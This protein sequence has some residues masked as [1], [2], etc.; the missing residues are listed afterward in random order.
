MLTRYKDD[1]ILILEIVEKASLQI[2]RSYEIVKEYSV[3]YGISNSAKRIKNNL[4]EMLDQYLLLAQEF[5]K[6]NLKKDMELQDIAEYTLAMDGAINGWIELL[7]AF[8]RK[9]K[10]DLSEE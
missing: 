8:Y 5:Y 6:D 1:Y 3:Q 2:H 10:Y 4:I 9:I 7:E